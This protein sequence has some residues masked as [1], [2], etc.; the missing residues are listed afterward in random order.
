MG[1]RGASGD[2]GDPKQ[3]SIVPYGMVVDQT[4]KLVFAALSKIR[5]IDAPEGA[6]V[7]ALAG[8]GEPYWPGGAGPVNDL[9]AMDATLGDAVDAALGW[10]DGELYFIDRAMSLVRK[11]VVQ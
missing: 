10:F 6:I 7:R 1:A 4:G 5:Q 2:N 11:V 9:P 8:S 3:A